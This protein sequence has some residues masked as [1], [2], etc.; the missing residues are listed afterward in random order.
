M[1]DK[2]IPNYNRDVYYHN[3]VIREPSLSSQQKRIIRLVID[4]RERNV[5]LFPSPNSYEINLVDEIMNVE[6]LSLICTEFPFDS[7]TVGSNNNML[8]LAYNSLVYPLAIEIGNY[9]ETLLASTIQDA[10]N[11]AVGGNNFIVSYN[12]LKDNFTFRSKNPFGL[13]FR[14]DTFLHSY[15]NSTDTA[16][17]QKS[18]GKLLGF[19]IYNYVS[20]VQSTNDAYVNVLNS[21]YKKDFN[22][23]GYIVLNID[24]FDLNKS[25]A[26]SIQNSFAIIS[27]H[28]QALSLGTELISKH[29]KPSLSKLRKLKVNIVDFYNNPYDFQNKD[30]RFELLLLCDF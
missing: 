8:Y 11:T 30:H 23:D 25:T 26:D 3:A 16:Y 19:G 7:Y 4:S 12:A 24:A 18:M 13:I 20:T 2:I 10:F 1:T 21:E 17:K 5:S 14:G 28:T 29:F 27:N 22:T 6:A 15:N 9:T